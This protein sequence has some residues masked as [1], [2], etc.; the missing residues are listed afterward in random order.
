[1]W[2]EQNHVVRLN[3]CFSHVMNKGFK[4]SLVWIYM[5]HVLACSV[6]IETK[7]VNFS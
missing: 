4:Y 2:T 6:Y 1:M 7:D 5:Y 3:K